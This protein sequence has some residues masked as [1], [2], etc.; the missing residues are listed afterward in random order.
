MNMNK[1]EIKAFLMIS[2]IINLFKRVLKVLKIK[3]FKA[4]LQKVRLASLL[5]ISVKSF[6]IKN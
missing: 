4:Y 1:I 5:T 6:W 3:M 2:I